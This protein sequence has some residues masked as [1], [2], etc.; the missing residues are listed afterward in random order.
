MEAMSRSKS[1]LA[2]H[3]R[4]R[5][6]GRG[7]QPR[8]GANLRRPCPDEHR[9]PDRPKARRRGKKDQSMTLPSRLSAR[10]AALAAALLSRAAPR[11]GRKARIGRS[12]PWDKFKGADLDRRRQARLLRQGTQS[13]LFRECRRHS[14]GYENDL[15]GHDRLFGSRADAR[16][17]TTNERPVRPV[18]GSGV[19]HLDATGPVTVVSKTQVATGDSGSYDKAQDKV[20]LIGHVTLSDG[21]NVTKGDKL[22]MTSRTAWRPSTPAP[23][24]AGCTDNSSRSRAPTRPNPAPTPRRRKQRSRNRS[25]RLPTFRA[26]SDACEASGRR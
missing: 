8:S 19:K 1:G 26:A 20:W 16:R 7:P 17:A 14:G 15:L 24:Q 22:P 13:G 12:L 9:S 3:D 4:A 23:S 11:C 25:R 2:R 6:S 21:Q 5:R 10:L 18:S